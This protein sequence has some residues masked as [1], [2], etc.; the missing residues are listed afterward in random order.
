VKRC[1]FAGR[2]IVNLRLN[3]SSQ[4][5][6]LRMFVAP[7]IQPGSF[8]HWLYPPGLHTMMCPCAQSISTTHTRFIMVHEGSP[9]RSLSIC[10]KTCGDITRKVNR[11]ILF[12]RCWGVPG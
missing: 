1:R 12:L 9:L 3:A 4:I 5:L 6:A 7:L 11:A 8:E 10:R 2:E